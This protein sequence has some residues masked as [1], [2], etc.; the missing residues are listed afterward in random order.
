[1][2]FHSPQ[3]PAKRVTSTHSWSERFQEAAA[4]CVGGGLY[5]ALKTSRSSVRVGGRKLEEAM[6]EDAFTTTLAHVGL[7]PHALSP[8]P[9]SRWHGVVA[10]SGSDG[11]PATRV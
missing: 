5:S 7:L 10:S 4:V 9:V 11:A 3:P 8:K 6:E 2:F 1:M